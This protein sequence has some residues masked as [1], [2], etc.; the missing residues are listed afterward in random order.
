MRKEH[1]N[2]AQAV[3]EGDDFAGC[4]DAIEGVGWSRRSNLLSVAACNPAVGTVVRQ[5]VGRSPALGPNYRQLTKL[6]S[7]TDV[8]LANQGFVIE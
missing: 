1:P 2:D 7:L 6:S 4:F 8:F 5:R 3:V